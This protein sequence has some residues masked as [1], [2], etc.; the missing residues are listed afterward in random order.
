MVVHYVCVIVLVV[1]I[2]VVDKSG[3]SCSV[4]VATGSDC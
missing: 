3:G 4:A 2:K 1:G